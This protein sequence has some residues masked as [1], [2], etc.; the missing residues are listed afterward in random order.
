MLNRNEVIGVAV[1]GAKPSGRGWRPDEIE[2]IDWATRQ[3]GLDLHALTV[4]QLENERSE[5]RVE[6]RSANAQLDRLLG[7]SAKRA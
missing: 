3:V 2:L 6:L 4:E 5:L 1:L 7:L